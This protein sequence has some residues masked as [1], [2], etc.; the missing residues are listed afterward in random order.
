MELKELKGRISDEVIDCIV[1]RL[2]TSELLCFFDH[3]YAQQS[4]SDFRKCE[5]KKQLLIFLNK[6]EI[7]YYS[8]E[9]DN[10]YN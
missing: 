4:M 5:T 7:P 9:F 6:M 8:E 1:A 2:K 3:Y 10:Y